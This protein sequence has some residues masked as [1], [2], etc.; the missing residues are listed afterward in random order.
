MLLGYLDRVLFAVK[1]ANRIVP[2]CQNIIVIIKI[3]IVGIS[4]KSDKADND[5]YCRN[6]DNHM[7][8]GYGRP[9]IVK[10]IQE[11]D[12]NYGECKYGGKNHFPDPDPVD[13]FLV[14]D[15]HHCTLLRQR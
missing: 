6:S 12:G 3:E 7:V 9:G 10:Y 11:H 5:K 4:K 1:E 14:I 13:I 8:L 2:E 15:F